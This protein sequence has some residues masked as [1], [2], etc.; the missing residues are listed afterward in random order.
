MAKM[1]RNPMP[2]DYDIVYR[3]CH[4]CNDMTPHDFDAGLEKGVWDCTICAPAAVEAWKAERE[5]ERLAKVKSDK[6]DVETSKKWNKEFN[7]CPC[8]TADDHD[9]GPVSPCEG[10]ASYKAD[11][12]KR[13]K[14]EAA[15]NSDRP[16]GGLMAQDEDTRRD[17]VIIGD[18]VGDANLSAEDM[19]LLDDFLDAEVRQG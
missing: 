8:P 4:E 1:G 5:A 16:T 12:V 9:F 13:D 17:F 14:V 7:D 6:A 18:L 15:K 10:S 11:K 19:E 3:K 2:H